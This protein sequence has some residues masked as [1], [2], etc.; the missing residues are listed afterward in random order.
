MLHYLITDNGSAGNAVRRYHASLTSYLFSHQCTISINHNHEV[1]LRF[2]GFIENEIQV[3]HF[4]LIVIISDTVTLFQR[5]V[6]RTL[7]L[8]FRNGYADNIGKITAQWNRDECTLTIQLPKVFRTVDL[9]S[10]MVANLFIYIP[11]HESNFGIT[12]SFTMSA[13]TA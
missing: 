8:Q 12:D 5:G 11:V 7:T 3:V 13:N 9:R 10:I 6:F 1:F 2:K 4:L